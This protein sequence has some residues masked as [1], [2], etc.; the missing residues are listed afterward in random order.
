MKGR[1]WQQ[2]IILKLHIGYSYNL[3]NGHPK[4]KYH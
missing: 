1:G 2:M 3:M 4:W